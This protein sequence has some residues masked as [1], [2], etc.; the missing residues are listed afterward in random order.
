MPVGTYATVGVY[1]T[2]AVEVQAPAYIPFDIWCITYEHRTVFKDTGQ[3]RDATIPFYLPPKS[4]CQMPD[5]YA[6]RLLA[7]TVGDWSIPIKCNSNS[8]SVRLHVVP[9]VGPSDCAF[10]MYYDYDRFPLAYRG[11]KYE[12]MYLSQMAEYGMNSPTFYGWTRP[13]G[14]DVAE[15]LDKAVEEN[16]LS[17][18]IPVM[19]LPCGSGQEIVDNLKLYGKHRDQW[20]EILGY[21]CDEPSL[22]SAPDVAKTTKSWNDA[23][24]RSATAISSG[25][26]MGFGD[27]LDVWVVHNPG[28]N[29]TI[30]NLAQRQKKELWMYNCQMRGTNAPWHRYYTGIYTFAAGVKGNMIWAYTH[31][32]NSCVKPDGTW[33]ALRVCEHVLPTKDGPMTTVGLEGYRDGVIDYRVLSQ[34]KREILACYG[35]PENATLADEAAVWLQRQID[36]VALGFWSEGHCPAYNNTYWWDVPDMAVPPISDMGQMR[37]VA[38]DYLQRLQKG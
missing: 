37:R 4:L 8:V 29:K 13:L 10:G 11:D 14:K 19:I 38:L 25:S 21:N 16:V 27:A 17:K 28:M 6:V 23:G 5:S 18:H 30:Q 31:D 1:N 24:M 34:L 33:N 32:K 2:D 26:V 36:R 35:K 20:P 3:E 22:V 7:K 9:Q 15:Q 12:R